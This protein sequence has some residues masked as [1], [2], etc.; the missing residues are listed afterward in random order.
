MKSTTTHGMSFFK[1][2]KCQQSH[3][4][5]TRSGETLI[6]LSYVSNTVA[7]AS[8]AHK[9]RKS[10]VNSVELLARKLGV[11]TLDVV[12]MAVDA[13]YPY[14]IREAMNIRRIAQG[15]HHGNIPPFLTAY[16]NKTLKT[17]EAERGGLTW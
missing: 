4:R 7:D 6:S 12:K 1:T 11:T 2:G 8:L 15:I 5:L 16:C 9:R 3:R 13:T 17:I 14:D 10:N